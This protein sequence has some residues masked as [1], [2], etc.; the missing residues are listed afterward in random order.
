MSIKKEKSYA[1]NGGGNSN[2]YLYKM[3]DLNLFKIIDLNV[4]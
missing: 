4:H 2:L 3:I 1:R